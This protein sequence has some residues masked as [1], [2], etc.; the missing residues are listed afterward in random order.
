[1]S[2]TCIPSKL[3]KIASLLCEEET[4][5]TFSGCFQFIFENRILEEL[6]EFAKA[7]VGEVH[8]IHLH[9]LMI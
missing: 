9:Y 7:D 8:I 2:S 5:V 6:A 1:M 3:Q 4:D